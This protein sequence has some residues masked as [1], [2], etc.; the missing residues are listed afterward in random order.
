MNK[1]IIKFIF[2]IFLVFCP[3]LPSILAQ[4]NPNLLAEFN[5]VNKKQVQKTFAWNGTWSVA[6]RFTPGTLKITTIS[7]TKFKFNI[8]ALNGANTGE[9]SG[10]ASIKANKA[11]FDDQANPKTAA[12]AYGCKMLFIHKGK[13][14]EIKETSECSA[15]GGNGVYL[16]G[17]Y[18]KGK[19]VINENNFVQLEV[20]PNLVVDKKFKL[21]VGKE[22][23][24]FL[25]DF[26]LINED[27]DLDELNSKV[28][29]G[30]VRGICP[31]NTGIIMF[32]DKANIWAAVTNLD[33]DKLTKIYYF[34]NNSA[35]T[36]KLPKT[37]ENWVED[38]RS[39]SENLQV[40]FKS[41][42]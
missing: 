17:E 5:R 6:T 37:I 39:S 8:N 25:N 22:Y 18:T 9:I 12:D 11:Y 2:A 40:I 7:A 3:N 26:Q 4:D 1:I 15:Y 32:D 13:S 16:G 30:C 33:T 10:T 23:E 35:W 41:K 42:K 24:N 14:I 34:T 29:S 21:L 19:P 31:W 20:F 38:K 27:K 28:F 36:E